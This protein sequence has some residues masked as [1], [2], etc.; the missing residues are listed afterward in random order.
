MQKERLV[1]LALLSVEQEISQT[2]NLED[3]IDKFCTANKNRRI[4][5]I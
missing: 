3:V 4:S 5:L 2:L 1:N